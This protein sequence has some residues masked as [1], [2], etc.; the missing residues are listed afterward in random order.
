MGIDPQMGQQTRPVRALIALGG[1]LP[2]QDIA[3]ELL[4]PKVFDALDGDEIRVLA[5]SSL[6]RTPAWPDPSAPAYVNAAAAIETIM[7]AEALL[8]RLHAIEWEFGRVRG[9]GRNQSRTL[10][11]DI[12]DFG[13]Q[14]IDMP[15]LTLPHPRAASRAFV[16]LPLQEV[17]P[18]WCDPVSRQEI[19]ALI[20]A[21]PDSDVSACV[22]IG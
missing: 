7:N 22:R 16:L 3:P 19:G 10:D 14:Q 4:L 2:W 12:V 11:L 18:D 17:A 5:R 20:A 13:G 6:W 15:D 9:E 8:Q 1:N 21:L